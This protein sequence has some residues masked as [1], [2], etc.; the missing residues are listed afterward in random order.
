MGK[1][2]SGEQKVITA[3]AVAKASG[4][5]LAAVKAAMEENRHA[6]VMNKAGKLVG[7]RVLAAASDQGFVIKKSG[8]VKGSTYWS[9]YHFKGEEVGRVN[10]DLA[11][12]RAAT[13]E[14]EKRLSIH[15]V[16]ICENVSDL[17]QAAFDAVWREPTVAA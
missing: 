10:E 2:Q 13:A 5:S 11:A 16:P 3:Q 15:G 4:L 14:L 7:A 8:R 9:F 6:L 17:P 12:A 1:T